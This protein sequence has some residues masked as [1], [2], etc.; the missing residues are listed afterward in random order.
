MI[1]G[2]HSFIHS[3]IYVR[4]LSASRTKKLRKFLVYLKKLYC[5]IAS[6]GSMST[7]Q[8]TGEDAT[9]R[10]SGPVT[11]TDNFSGSTEDNHE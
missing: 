1:F 3:F 11:G 5:H 9:V 4:K 2:F 8:C 6:I 10:S 7:G